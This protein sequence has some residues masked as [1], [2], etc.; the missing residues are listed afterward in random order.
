M[1]PITIEFLPDERLILEPLDGQREWLVWKNYTVLINGQ[2]VLVPE[3]FHTDLASV[4]PFVRIFIDDDD[5]DILKPA[6]IH[7]FLYKHNGIAWPMHEPPFTRRECDAILIAGM[8][9]RGARFWRRSAV[10]IGVRLGGWVAWR[11]HQKGR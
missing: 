7:D 4:P 11:N 2:Q 1:L 3:N 5:P 6:V 9:A 8:K 10:W